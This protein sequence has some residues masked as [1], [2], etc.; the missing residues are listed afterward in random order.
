MNL[1]FEMVNDETISEIRLKQLES[2]VAELEKTVEDYAKRFEE[3]ATVKSVAPHINGDI[4]MNEI[5]DALFVTGKDTY[6]Y[7]EIL[8][9]MG[10]K[11][12]RTA[13]C[14]VFHKDFKD[15]LISAGIK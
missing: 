7:K 5:G 9:E 8:K 2:R 12:E 4:K 3:F 13:K 11:W 15:T 6:K 1:E 14:W 10:G